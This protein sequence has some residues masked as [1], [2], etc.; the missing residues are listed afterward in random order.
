[1]LLQPPTAQDSFQ[2]S[3]SRLS[4]TFLRRERKLRRRARIGTHRRSQACSSALAGHLGPI[5]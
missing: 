5:S 2:N 1:M 3:C 4:A